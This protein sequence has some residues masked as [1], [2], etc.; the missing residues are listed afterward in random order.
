MRKAGFWSLQRRL[1]TLVETLIVMSLIALVAGAIGFGAYS[2]VN[3]E[4]FRT[5][6]R[7]VGDQLVLAQDIMLILRTNVRVHLQQ[8]GDGLE[9]KV[10]SAGKLSPALERFTSEPVL[11]TAIS[12]FEF[13]DAAGTSEEADVTLEFLSGGS[14]MSEGR[15]VLYGDPQRDEDSRREEIVL[16][17]YPRTILIGESLESE[18]YF[19]QTVQEQSRQYY[20]QYVLEVAPTRV[21]NEKRKKTHSSS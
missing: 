18:P 14:Q 10:E 20:P 4:R 5:A 17:G 12:A 1:V 11:L 8:T 9:V 13:I 15:L 16:Y 3:T 7:Q 21:E 6:V 2:A 19:K